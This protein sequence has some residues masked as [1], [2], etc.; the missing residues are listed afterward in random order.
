[1]PCR[2]LYH[3][4]PR[5]NRK[6]QI[7]SFVLYAISKSVLFSRSV[8]ARKKR[9]FPLCNYRHRPIEGNISH[10]IYHEEEQLTESSVV[11]VVA[12]GYRHQHVSGK[13]Q[14][15]MCSK[16][17]VGKTMV[18]GTKTQKTLTGFEE[19]FNCILSRENP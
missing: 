4:Q 10:F 17:I 13:D 12:F 14:C 2:L 11:F 19:D 6:F 5:M 8:T 7:L 16:R 1:M 3:L 15:H 18:L 9:G